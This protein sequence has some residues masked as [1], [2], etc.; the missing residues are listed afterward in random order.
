MKKITFVGVLGLAVN[1]KGEFLLTKRNQPGNHRTNAKWQLPGGGMEFGETP[2]QVL[3]REMEEE[4]KVSVRILY[5][6][7]IVRTH[8]YDKS[9]AKLQVILLTYLIDIGGQKA[10]IGNHEASELG[11][12]SADQVHK[13][14]YLPLTIEFINTAQL[15][16]RKEKILDVLR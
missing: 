4:L 14:D 16:I 6:Q 10:K 5:P 12:F 9:S 3:A 15:I 7:P 13:L 1:K 8:V 11:W 2:E